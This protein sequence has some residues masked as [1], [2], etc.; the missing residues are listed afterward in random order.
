MTAN[1]VQINQ[2]LYAASGLFAVLVIMDIVFYF[3]C[4]SWMGQDHYR[5][6]AIVN[7]LI[8]IILFALTFL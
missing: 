8:A 7:G 2:G 6:Q 1:A 3:K 5:N 4:N